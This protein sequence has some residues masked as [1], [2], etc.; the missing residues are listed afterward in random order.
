MSLFYRMVCRY[1]RISPPPAAAMQGSSSDR[2]AQV[3]RGSV[4]GIELLFGTVG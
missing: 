1:E 3:R 4:C 2:R